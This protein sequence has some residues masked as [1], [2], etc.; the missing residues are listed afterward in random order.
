MN[1]VSFK[2]KTTVWI[3]LLVTLICAV[4]IGGILAMS[5][6]VAG[7][8]IKQA[9]IRT[10]ERNADEIEYKNGLLEIEN[11]FVFNADGIY[12]EV[13][14]ESFELISANPPEISTEKPFIN[15]EITEF[16]SDGNNRYVYDLYLNFNKY[17]YEIDVFSGQIINSEADVCVAD[18]MIEGEYVETS[19]RGGISTREAIDIALKHAGANRE[20]VKIISAEIPG[21][22]NRQVF[23]IEFVC[24]Q[25][26]YGGVWIRGTAPASAGESAFGAINKAIIYIIPLFI[27]LAALGSYFISKKTISPV[28]K[29]TASA[30][31]IN[32]GNDLSK[33]IKSDASSDEIA[34]LAATFNEMLERLQI[35]FENEK[36]FT[37]DA[38]HE[39]RTPLAVIKAECEFALS[40]NADDRD[41]QEALVSV[42]EQADK[43]TRLV[44][45]LLTLSRAEQGIERFNFEEADLSLL[46]QEVCNSFIT[47]NGIIL[48]SDVSENI[49]MNMDVSLIS[50]LLENLLSNAV[51]YGKENGK[52]K[53]TLKKSDSEISLTVEDNG[54]GIKEDVLPKIWSRFYRADP[55]RSSADS[56]GIGLALVKKIAELHGGTARAESEYGKGSKFIIT[57]FEK[58]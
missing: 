12:C 49:Y 9:L 51:R 43:M 58:V 22:E 56:F 48:E 34:T 13:Y 28:E 17:E 15:G 52:I 4:T 8:E 38:S 7:A 3:T 21:Y 14:N 53:V 30:R 44:S 31:E 37:S 19:F 29:I 35:S 18:S 10:V 1:K 54:I 39:L 16:S 2:I 57:F 24:T 26:L 6:R 40:D 32:S 50:R 47:S 42:S 55:S 25:P 33:R 20:S 45:A 41:R 27:I 46:V 5:R 11:D 23:K 36:Q